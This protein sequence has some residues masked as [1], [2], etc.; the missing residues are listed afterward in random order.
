M[1]DRPRPLLDRSTDLTH[2]RADHYPRLPLGRLTGERR[3][4]FAT[5]VRK[6]VAIVQAN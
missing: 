2:L 6:L 5:L 4:A 1:P 3:D